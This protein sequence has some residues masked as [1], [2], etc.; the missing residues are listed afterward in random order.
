M[1]A[2]AFIQRCF[3]VSNWVERSLEESVIALESEAVESELLES[4]AL[5]SELLKFGVL[6]SGT[7]E[8]G[9]LGLDSGALEGISGVSATGDRGTAN[10]YAQWG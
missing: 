5:K 7:L 1:F 6:E 10:V 4:G 9:M 2:L 8:F 3:Q